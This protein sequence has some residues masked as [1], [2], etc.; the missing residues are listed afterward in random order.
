MS[1]VQG[2]LAAGDLPGAMKAAEKLD[3]PVRRHFCLWL[4]GTQ[5]ERDKAAAAALYLRSLQLEPAGANPGGYDNRL[6]STLQSIR[7]KALVSLTPAEGGYLVQVE[8]FQELEDLPGGG[9]NSPGGATFQESTPLQRDL[10]LV[11][12][13]STP[14]GWIPQGRD[15]TLEQDMLHRLNAALSR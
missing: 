12:G 2:K 4:A 7:R 9:T 5:E 14:S 13:Q 6:E 3:V 1:A 11:V 10:E 15:L 8:A